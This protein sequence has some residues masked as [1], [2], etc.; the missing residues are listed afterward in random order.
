[1]IRI[2]H[3]L[4]AMDRAGTETMLMNYYRAIDRDEIQFDFAVSAEGKCNYDD[5]IL[6][7]GGRI[8]HYPRYRGVNHFAYKKWW[9]EF[10][11]EHSEY[12]IVHGHIGSTA[13]IYLKIAKKYGCYAIAHSHN[14][15]GAPSPRMAVW[16]AYSYRTRYVADYFFGCSM[17]AVV[18]RYG[19]EVAN[20][21]GRSCVIRNAIDASLYSYDPDVSAQVRSELGIGDELVVGTVGRL[22]EQ[23]NPFFIIRLIEELKKTGDRFVFVWA[24]DGELKDRILDQLKEKGIEDSVKM[25]GVRNDIP[26]LLQAFDVFVFPSV[27]EG[28]GVAAVEAQAA[29]VPTLCSTNVVAEAGVTDLCSFLSL[30]DIDEW[31]RRIRSYIGYEKKNEYDS[32]AAAG[33]DIHGAAETLTDFYKGVSRD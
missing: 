17:D 1:M 29:G 3:V 12:K 30:D 11:K 14:I 20:D 26:R 9:N 10:F 5:E 7:L 4:T 28:L 6:S 32:I 15:W 27:F 8:Y 13:A 2:L 22:T 25:L 19:A 24:G 31:T 21:P 16:R 18:A 23:K 33:Y